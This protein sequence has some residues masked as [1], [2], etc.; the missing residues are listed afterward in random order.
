M[1]GDALG[2]NMASMN[3]TWT[4]S[5]HTGA[6]PEAVLAALTDPDA[7][8]RW[9][10]VAFDVHV[11][12]ADDRQLTLSACG[13]VN[14]IVRYDVAPS[15]DG[16]SEVRAS[17]SVAKGRGFMAGLLAEATAGLLRAGALSHAVNRI[18]ATA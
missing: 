17:V 5:A 6:A 13:P 18:A 15:D 7:V 3:A 2:L 9:S 4:A 1:C 10:P 14:M 8:A 11:H 16:S 12:A